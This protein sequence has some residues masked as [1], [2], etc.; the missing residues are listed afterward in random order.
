MNLLRTIAFSVVF[1]LLILVASCGKRHSPGRVTQGPINGLDS[2]GVEKGSLS[3]PAALT[4]EDYRILALPM[5]E[6]ILY[7]ESKLKSL[8]VEM[9]GEVPL[10]RD[11]SMKAASE[12]TSSKHVVEEGKHKERIELSEIENEWKWELSFLERLYGDLDFSGKVEIADITAIAMHYGEVVA[13]PEKNENPNYATNLKR[14]SDGDIVGIADITPL[15][16]NYGEELTKY[17]VYYRESE[18]DSWKLIDNEDWELERA[19]ATGQP[20]LFRAVWS[21]EFNRE[22][23]IH[24]QD[25]YKLAVRPVGKDGSVG[26]Y[27]DVVE[28]TDEYQNNA[29]PEAVL[30]IDDGENLVD[31]IEGMEPLTVDFDASGS[32]DSDGSIVKYEWDWENDGTYDHDSGTDPTVEHEYVDPGHY[33]ASVQVTDDWGAQDWDSVTITVKGRPVIESFTVEPTFGEAPVEATFTVIAQD[34]DGNGITEVYFDFDGVEERY[35]EYGPIA[36]TQL[37]PLDEYRYEASVVHEFTRD[38]LIGRHSKLFPS[39]VRV[40]DNEGQREQ[41]IQEPLEVTHAVP[42]I[43]LTVDPDPAYIHFGQSVEFDAS[44]ST[45][46]DGPN[47]LPTKFEFDFDGDEI[48]DETQEYDNYYDENGDP[49]E[50]G[51][52]ISNYPDGHT[53]T[54]AGLYTATVKAYDKDYDTCNEQYEHVDDADVEIRVYGE[55]ENVWRDELVD[56]GNHPGDTWTNLGQPCIALDI[57]PVTGWPGIVYRAVL[58]SH[59]GENDTRPLAAPLY[60]DKQQEINGWREP[61]RYPLPVWYSADDHEKKAEI[62]K[63]CDLMYHRTIQDG[64]SGEYNPYIAAT[65]VGKPTHGSPYQPVGIKVYN[66]KLP[67]WRSNPWTGAWYITNNSVSRE[68]PIRL[69]VNVTGRFVHYHHS[70]GGD[71]PTRLNEVSSQSVLNPVI[72]EA[73][74][75]DAGITHDFKATLT[76]DEEGNWI[77]HSWETGALYHYIESGEDALHYELKPSASLTDWNGPFT[78]ISSSIWTTGTRSVALDYYKNLWAGYLWIDEDY[79]LRFTQPSLTEDQVAADVGYWC[80]FDYDEGLGIP[81]VAYEKIVD[82]NVCVFAQAYMD[83]DWLDNAVEVVN[84]G[85]DGVSHLDLDVWNGYIF[86]AY[87]DVIADE[88]RCAILDFFNGNR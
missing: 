30:K 37:E 65:V 62:G 17:N 38:D 40:V 82:D 6:R 51:Y 4:E 16:I 29:Y 42:H 36:P 61:D 88:I 22:S 26:P 32:T 39:T 45:D 20:L 74:G 76:M 25:G 84:L 81:C 54:S 66:C 24:V 50:P 1:A 18:E 46:A 80:D 87:S 59:G 23:P 49:K 43:A 44:D 10:E 60:T 9:Y 33:T 57:N 58:A 5:D 83:D 7:L 12:V 68:Y 75:S 63:Q 53:Y 48:P 28:F 69:V 34:T 2:A 14:N 86:V 35:G 41:A 64:A 85:E 55:L 21:G 15:A 67:P 78:A 56:D 13:D 72:V 52:G 11:S 19:D 3:K 8:L 27:S 47:G 79:E 70:L 31:H 73:G 71:P 77:P